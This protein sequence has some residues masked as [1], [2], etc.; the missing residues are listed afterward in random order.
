MVIF[1]LY[2]DTQLIAPQEFTFQYGY[3]STHLQRIACPGIPSFTFQYGYISTSFSVLLVSRKNTFTFQY[4]YI[5]TQTPFCISFE[6]VPFTF[7]YGYIST[8]HALHPKSAVSYLHSSMVI[9]QRVYPSLI[10]LIL[11]IYIP[12]WLYF[13]AC[14]TC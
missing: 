13:N 4:G 11:Y 8:I 6:A 5:S 9:F 3:I 2:T 7:Q 10:L 1:Q 14:G 12:V